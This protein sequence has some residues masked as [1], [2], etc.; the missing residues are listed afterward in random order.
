MHPE[1]RTAAV[2]GRPGQPHAVRIRSAP[3]TL[4][5]SETRKAILVGAM[6][7]VSYGAVLLLTSPTLGFSVSGV[8]PLV[9]V[10]AGANLLLAATAPR[11]CGARWA[12]AI[13][14]SAHALLMTAILFLVGGVRMSVLVFVYMFPIFHAGMLGP[15][16]AVFVTANVA[17][18]SYCLMTVAEVTGLLLPPGI[19]RPDFAPIPATGLVVIAWV[20]LNFLA[21]YAVRYG[22][23]LRHYAADLERQVAR[24]TAELTELNAELDDKNRALETKQ[25]ELRTLVYAVTHDLKNPTNS[26]LLTADLLQER[27]AAAL[28]PQGREDLERIVTLASTTEDMIRDLLGLFRIT[29]AVEQPAW[30]DVDAQVASALETL[31]PQIDAKQVRVTVGEVPRMWARPT[32]LASVVQNLLSN[33]VKYVSAGCGQI[34]VSGE[35]DGD[36]TLLCVRDDGVGIPQRYHRGIFELF[37]RVPPEEQPVD[38]VGVA[39]SG[40]GLAI[41]KRIVEAHGGTIWVESDAG[42]GSR[43]WVRLPVPAEVRAA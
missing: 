37:G 5:V 2:E 7:M 10:A 29:S 33:A 40:V 22:R 30:V 21:L 42:R 15:N 36:A 14:G 24:R 1:G 18:L 39:G 23:Q 8:I 26:I 32:Q 19:K 25:D 9:A 35:I 38:G 13:Y 4:A 41:A 11:W 6:G 31:R 12:G 20:G 17:A 16:L 28:S 27:E 34:E 43:F 3:D